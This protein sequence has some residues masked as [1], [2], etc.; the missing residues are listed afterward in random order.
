MRFNPETP[1]DLR[2]LPPEVGL[3]TVSVLKATIEARSEIGE[4]KGYCS[5]IPNP[6]MLMSI[7][8]AKESV[9]S[10]KIEDIHTT[11]EH[12]LQGQVMPEKELSKVDKEVMRYREAIND[13]YQNY[14][15]YGLS[16]RTILTIHK[17]LI[18]ESDG[19]RKQQNA[20]SNNRTGEKIYTPPRAT[21]IER[22]IGNWENFVNSKT[23]QLD[24][25]LKCAFAHYQFEAI[26]PF[27]DGNGRTG[28][29]LLALHLVSENLLT[30]PVL[31]MSGYL[32][33]NRD[34]YYKTLKEITESGD[35]ESFV[36]FMLEGFRVQSVKTK[37]KLFQ[38]ME[39]YESLVLLIN[40]V[41]P[42]IKARETVDHL[43]TYPVTTPTAYAETLDIHFQTASKHLNELSEG[44]ILR[45][46]KSGKHRLYYNVPIFKM[47]GLIKGM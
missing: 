12:I 31:Y 41:H 24:P 42:K 34:K 32:N 9:E 3:D 8:V 7:A 46:T 2:L 14:K 17:R 16:T 30:H 21:E 10:S 6:M 28:R 20:I 27:G 47:L 37:I 43:F 15:K 33:K 45:S 44:G 5:K 23:S 26:H 22:L 38:M 40:K 1:Y 35:W 29:I 19:F 39:E 25:L 13:G 4:L 36:L 18:L 11:V